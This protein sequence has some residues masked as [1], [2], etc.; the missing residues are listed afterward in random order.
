[1]TFTKSRVLKPHTPVSACCSTRDGVFRGDGR[2][3]RVVDAVQC[4]AGGGWEYLYLV[5]VGEDLKVVPA[6][7]LTVQGEGNDDAE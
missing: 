5:A 6:S 4:G 2:V 1:M 7:G 3:L